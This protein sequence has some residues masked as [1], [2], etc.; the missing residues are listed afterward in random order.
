MSNWV[1]KCDGLGKK[2]RK[3]SD[4]SYGTLRDSLANAFIG[5]GNRDDLGEQEFWA[6]QEV[7]FEINEGE[8]VGI[9]GRNGA[10]KS[11]LLKVISRI[12]EL[13]AG[14]LQIKG[15]V[16]SLLEVGTGFHPEL[17]GRENIFMNGA[18]LGLTKQEIRT[19]FDEIVDFSGVEEF[20][21]TPVKRYS[22]G[23]ATRLGFS[24]AAHLEPE[25]LIVDEVLSVGDAEFRKKCLGK[26]RDVAAGGRTVLFVSHNLNAIRALCPRGIYLNQG[27]IQE[28]SLDINALLASYLQS[29]IRGEANKWNGAGVISNSYIM[30]KQF[31]IADQ[32]MSSIE[33]TVT[34]D[35]VLNVVIEVDV[36]KKNNDLLVGYQISDDLGNVLYWSYCQDF[37]GQEVI[38]PEGRVV[39][40]SEIPENILNDG[41]YTLTLIAGVLN[42]GAIFSQES[43]PVKFSIEVDGNKNRAGAWQGRRLS[44]ISPVIE[45]KIR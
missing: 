19:K 39:V 13:S 16:A 26:M 18:V 6:L 38:L 7:N 28:D 42:Q 30:P 27:K 34:S 36:L 4:T 29:Q 22:S 33:R 44:A 2:F 11:T 37:F 31:H 24:V 25:I 20:L 1:I 45:W 43:S 40:S 21:D 3:G 8:V 12:T 41:E 32:S 23:M 10:G 35:E 9:I 14:K 15:R 5:R 17:T